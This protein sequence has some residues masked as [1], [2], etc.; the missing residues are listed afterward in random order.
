MAAYQLHGTQ[1]LKAMLN[2]YPHLRA[3]EKLFRTGMTDP[4]DVLR[5]FRLAR[6]QF[7]FR[8]G[9]AAASK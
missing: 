5:H 6:R 3:V 7:A 8:D 1:K 4:W 9:T 2:E